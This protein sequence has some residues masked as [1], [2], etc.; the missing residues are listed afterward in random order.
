MDARTSSAQPGARDARTEPGPRRRP[1]SRALLTLLGVALTAGVVTAAITT[2]ISSYSGLWGR[3][4]E[5]SASPIVVL[6]HQGMEQS[7]STDPVGRGTTVGSASELDDGAC[8]A[9]TPVTAGNWYYRMRI[10][11]TSATSVANGTTFKIELF[12]DQVS[13][14]ALYVKQFAF[15]KPT[16]EACLL[17]WD[18]GAGLLSTNAYTAKVTDA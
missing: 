14:G 6:Y 8:L 15:S 12:Q 1:S 13:K 7:P 2:S 5:F 11:E 18:I 10:E 17:K 9:F 4:H 3:A 16:V